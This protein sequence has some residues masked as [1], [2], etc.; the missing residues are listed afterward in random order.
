MPEISTVSSGSV[1]EQSVDAV[2]VPDRTALTGAQNCWLAVELTRQSPSRDGMRYTEV[3]P[4][5]T[6]A[7][8]ASAGLAAAPGATSSSSRSTPAGGVSAFVRP[9]R[10]PPTFACPEAVADPSPGAVPGPG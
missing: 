7:L 6:S 3:P 2:A 1:G 5:P 8:R 4:G 10:K 9:R